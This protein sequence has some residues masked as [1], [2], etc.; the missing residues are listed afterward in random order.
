MYEKGG[1]QLPYRI[2][3]IR[4]TMRALTS[5]ERAV[6]IRFLL[7]LLLLLSIESNSNP[8]ASIA[9]SPDHRKSEVG[10]RCRKD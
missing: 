1:L 4:R 7:L 8:I 2:G 10:T 9:F 6:V 5:H 3:E